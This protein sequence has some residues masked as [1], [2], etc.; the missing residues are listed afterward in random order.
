MGKRF[1]IG[2]SALLLLLN[3]AGC[4]KSAEKE[5]ATAS[6]SAD[7][8]S[9]EFSCNEISVEE[10]TSVNLKDYCTVP[11]GV[12]VQAPSID[13]SKVGEK[14]ISITVTDKSGN[15]TMRT[16][17]VTVTAKPTPTPEPTP[18]PTPEPTPEP[19]APQQNTNTNNYSNYSR[20]YTNNYSN[21]SNNNSGSSS[22][23]NSSSQDQSS[24]SDSG[25]V[26]I[27][28]PKKVTGYASFPNSSYGGEAG[29]YSACSAH[30]NSNGGGACYPSSDGSGYVY[31]GG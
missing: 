6:S 28:E 30:M 12:T 13:T 2:A 1:L 18:T 31:L 15:L 5:K 29:A 26:T 4:S 17:K 23:S 20:N 14:N 24:G 19:A 11:D 8:K 10:G 9:P 27:T 7:V 3:T 16:I 25:S 22:N 21:Y